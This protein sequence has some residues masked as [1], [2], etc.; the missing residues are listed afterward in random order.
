MSARVRMFGVEIDVVRMGDAVARIAGWL[1]EPSEVCRFVVTPNVDHTVVVQTN[2]ALQAVYRDAHLVLADGAPIILA[3][4]LLRRPLPER[5]AGSELVPHLFAHATPAR[6]VRVF[7]LGAGPGVA[8]RAADRIRQQWPGVDIVGT[9][10]PPLGFEKDPREE[11]NILARVADAQPELLVVGLGAPKQEIWVH[12]H[13]RQL[14]AKV[15]LCVGATID[16]LA[17]EKPQAPVW[18]RRTGLE[19]IH[20]VATEPRRLAGRY[21]K[22]A[23]HFPQLVLREWWSRCEA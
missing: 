1:D 12:K 23:W 8:D 11:A 3:S 15:A 18:M 21:A 2:T 14:A 20:R 6:P 22:D 4:R 13:H 5:V 7:L 9:Y 10:C 16:F 19:W 17:G